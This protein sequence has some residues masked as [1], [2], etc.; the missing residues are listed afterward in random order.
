MKKTVLLLILIMSFGMSGKAQIAPLHIKYFGF[1][2]VDYYIDDPN[3][4]VFLDNYI[5]EVDSFSNIAQMYVR[6]YY[7]TIISRVNLMD[8]HCVRPVIDISAVFYFTADSNAPSGK[9]YDLHPDYVSR[10]NTFR[11]TNISVLDSN[12]IAAFYIMDEPYWNGLDFNELNQTCVL[13][14]QDFPEIPLMFIEAWPVVDSVVVPVDIDLLGFDKYGVYDVSTDS[15]YIARLEII[16]NKRNKS[17]QKI[18]LVMDVQWV[19][20][21]ATALGWT[22]D[23][24][25][26]VV[27]N[28]Y[29]LAVADTDIVGIAGF[30]W[31]GL[32][33]GWLGARSLP[34]SVKN[35]NIVIGNMI[36]ANYNPCSP[37]PVHYPESANN[38]LMV[39]PN[40]AENF[41]NFSRQGSTDELNI[42]IYNVMGQETY[43]HVFKNQ[44]LSIDLTDWIR[45][46]YY[47]TIFNNKGYFISGGVFICH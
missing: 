45:G 5:F 10:W 25:K 22:Q 31:P 4:S 18:M 41:I 13:V 2:L 12:K 38:N 27:Q 19:D 7:D 30:T 44:H 3:D 37:L 34:E 11:T 6:N 47:Y 36:K 24:L 40:P 17:S 21:Y 20:H 39:F 23:T 15:D 29:N 14:K 28:Y 35:K 46:F 8:A 16:K 32:A 1:A 9:N 43:R 26:Y 42:A 33:P